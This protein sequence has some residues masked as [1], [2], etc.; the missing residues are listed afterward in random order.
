MENK[1]IFQ[2]CFFSYLFFD[3]HVH[4]FLDDDGTAQLQDRPSRTPRGVQ[5]G[6]VLEQVLLQV[7]L[8]TAGHQL[9]IGRAID[10]FS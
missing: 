5:F 10:V 7:A 4:E 9:E 8:G 3:T 6:F 2:F 1:L